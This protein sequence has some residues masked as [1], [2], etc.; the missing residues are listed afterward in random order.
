MTTTQVNYGRSAEPNDGLIVDHIEFESDPDGGY[1]SKRTVS[2]ERAKEW[3]SR[4][5]QL[6]ASW[7]PDHEDRSRAW[8]FVTEVV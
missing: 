6:E 7:A 5:A 3:V 4:H 2:V 8:L 1:S